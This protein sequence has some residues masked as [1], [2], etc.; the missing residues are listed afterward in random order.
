[1]ICNPKANTKDCR[2]PTTI[3]KGV[4]PYVY[5]HVY[6]SNRYLNC[7]PA[8]RTVC[9]NWW[10]Q[11]FGKYQRESYLNPLEDSDYEKMKADLIKI[12][13]DKLVDFM[14]WCE[15]N[16]WVNDNISDENKLKIKHVFRSVIAAQPE[17]EFNHPQINK[18][19][20][21]TDFTNI[22]PKSTIVSIKG[23]SPLLSDLL[24]SDVPFDKTF[25][26][27]LKDMATQSDALYN[28]YCKKMKHP[29]VPATEKIKKEYLNFTKTGSWYGASLKRVRPDYRTDTI[30]SGKNKK[31]HDGE[32]DVACTKNYAQ[33][34]GLNGGLFVAHCGIHPINLGFHVIP[35]CEGLNDCFSM[36]YCHYLRAP[37]TT[38]TDFN[39]GGQ[40]YAMRREPEFFSKTAFIIDQPHHQ[41][42][43]QCSDAFNSKHW[44]SKGL[45]KYKSIN[46]STSEQRNKFLN[47]VKTMSTYMSFGNL[48][49]TVRHL[50]EMDNTGNIREINGLKKW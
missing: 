30:N 44:K 33:F 36:M 31:G 42:H 14:D 29:H 5:N 8:L 9:H 37:I 3:Y 18:L 46:F 49:I 34:R 17:L 20:S 11:I 35:N 26:I 10:Q 28:K 15:E 40:G 13:Y 47:K 2:N 48:M 43:T 45:S 7:K 50:M 6:D 24:L 1:M 12:K 22:L 19:I 38:S 23:W 21:N 4:S 25:Y 32:E 27:L 16:M 41:G 39:C